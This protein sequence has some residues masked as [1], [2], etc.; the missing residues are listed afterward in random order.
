MWH[1]IFFKWGELKASLDMISARHCV[2]PDESLDE[3]SDE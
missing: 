2:V 1:F 3:S